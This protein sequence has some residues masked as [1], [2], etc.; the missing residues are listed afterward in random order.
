MHGIEL[1]YNSST[2]ALAVETDKKV[3]SNLDEVSNNCFEGIGKKEYCYYQEM[4]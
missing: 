3:Y 1:N 4:F 2:Y